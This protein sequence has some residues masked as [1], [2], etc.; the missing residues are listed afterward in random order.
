MSQSRIFAIDK[1]KAALDTDDKVERDNRLQPIYEEVHAKFDELYPEQT[2]MIDECMYKLQK[3]VVRRWLLD[4]GKRVDG[5]GINE[6]VLFPQ[7]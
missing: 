4:E 3:F 5:R 6:T 2:A 7:K 1:V